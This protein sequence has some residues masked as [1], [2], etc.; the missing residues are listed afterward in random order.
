VFIGSNAEKI[1]RSAPCP[2][3]AVPKAAKLRKV[4]RIMVPIDL[5]Q[6]KKSFLAEV[7]KLQA[8]FD[9]TVDFLWVK[10]PHNIENEERV[11]EELTEILAA[12]G[13]ANATLTVE[14]SVFPSDAILWHADDIEADIIVMPTHARRGL[15]HWFSGSLTEDTVNH[16]N[17]PVWTFKLDKGEAS[18]EL[19]SVRDAHGKPE[20]KKI[21]LLTVD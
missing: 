1:V 15:S 2:V 16:V 6:I 21:E 11:I 5:K 20:Y 4:K 19:E 14:R 8:K 17:I 7:S 18:V 9:A 10:T 12:N 13:M 3:I